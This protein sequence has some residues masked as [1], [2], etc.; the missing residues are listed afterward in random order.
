VSTRR[1]TELLLLL[2]ATPPVLLIFALIQAHQTGEFRTTSLIVPGGLLVAF[3]VAHLAVRQFAKNADPGLLPVTFVLAGVG[4]GMVTR[5]DP[6]TAAQQVIWLF[7]G[8]AAL[9]GTLI[10]VPS[11]ERLSQY[12]YTLGLAG[13]VLLLLP[14]LP[15][16]GHEVNGSRLWLRVAGLSLQPG[17][18]AKVLIVLFLAAYLA[19]NREMLSI[20]TRRFLGLRLPEPRTLGPLLLMWAISLLVLIAEKDLGSSLIFFAIFL[21][22]LYVAT[23]RPAYVVVGLL[24]FSAGASVTYF[25]FRHVRLRVDIWLH[26]FADAAGRGYQLVQSMFALAAGGLTGV[27]LGSGMPTRIP[28][29]ATDFIF[30]AIGEELG[31]LGGAAIVLCFLV[32]AVRGLATAARAK[33]DMAAFT[34]TGLVATVTLQAFIIVGG[35]T[36]LI[37]L[38]GVT[39]PFMSAGGS[40]LLSTF[41]ALA[42]LLRAG[43]EGTGTATE[44]QTTSTDLG[45]LGRFALGKRL[46]RVMTVLAVLLSALVA[47]LTW[48]QVVDAHRLQNS[49]YNTRNLAAEARRPRGEIVTAD[50]VVLA[51]SRKGSGGVYE[52]VYPEGKM[53]AHTVGY[54]SPRYGRTGIEAAEN[55][56]LVGGQ[57]HFA[58]WSDVIDAAA[59]RQVPGDDVVL[60]LDSRVQRAA[61]EALSGRTG[62]CVVL[63]PQTGAVLAAASTPAYDPNRIDSDWKSLHSSAGNAPLIDRGRLSLYP[64]GSTFK[65]VTLTGALGTGVATTQTTYAGPASMKIGNAPVNNF[66]SGAYGKIDLVT[67]LEHSVNTVFAQLAVSLG[68]P[69][70]VR[71]AEAFGFS[72]STSGQSIPYDLSVK[73]SLMPNPAEMTTWETAWA[74]VGQPVGEHKSPAGPQATVMQ[75]ALVAAG[76]GNGGRIMA[77]YVVQSVH[78]P[79]GQVMASTSSRLMGTATDAATAQQV[80]SAMR[81]VVSAG[82]GHRAQ[83]DGVKVAGKT[84]TAEVGKDKP[85]NAWF[86]AFAPAEN[87]T[88]A[89]AIMIEG[90]GVGGQV[91]APAAKPVLEAALAA[92]KRKK[93]K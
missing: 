37:P 7:V 40:S 83:I 65:V 42:L 86:I 69:S 67:A 4:L 50:G 43:D 82:S 77:P 20:S 13:V 78:D 48:L 11:L 64:P 62:A 26:P 1:T 32:F 72:Q 15:V 33:T 35:V 74:G 63:D 70:L 54:F 57:R 47:N 89:M 66:E 68:A 79:E 73:N 39:L 90:G 84:G 23:G 49:V 59:G 30:S 46:T 24:L 56:V 60:T 27:G 17:E 10:L 75:M 85:T 81:K 3:L 87:P 45:V 76:I 91:A 71:Q 61:M 9:V 55:D 38:T 36:R 93:G 41:I 51:R 8:V 52:R 2:A 5:L 21:A 53:A 12:K 34:A 31:L 14:A 58:N 22:M 28:E 6:Q 25:A 80:A 16:I 88:V 18:L 29:V 92:Q 19:E 44:M